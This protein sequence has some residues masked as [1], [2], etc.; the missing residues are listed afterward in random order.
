MIECRPPF[1]LPWASSDKLYCFGWNSSCMC[2][3]LRIADPGITDSAQAILGGVYIS[4]VKLLQ[5]CMPSRWIWVYALSLQRSS[6]YDSGELRVGVCS[7]VTVSDS[8]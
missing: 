3:C 7:T 4:V 2:L 8:H 1:I 5:L 6:E